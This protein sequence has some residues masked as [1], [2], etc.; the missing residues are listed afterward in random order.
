MMIL[1]SDSMNG[2]ALILIVEDSP[3]Q[4]KHLE[5]ILSEQGYRVATADSGG[6]ALELIA[7][8]KPNMVISDILMPEMDG[9]ELCERDQGI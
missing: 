8:E 3:T 7:T 2:P 4:A 5:L 1:H 9:F 6:N